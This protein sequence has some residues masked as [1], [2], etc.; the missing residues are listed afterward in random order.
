M[1]LPTML[2]ERASNPRYTTWARS[3]HSAMEVS[4]RVSR[5]SAASGDRSGPRSAEVSIFRIG[6]SEA[7][8]LEK[9]TRSCSKRLA[10]P[11]TTV[12]G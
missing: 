4:R 2:S 6:I 11:S 8:I 12:E 5:V 10:S 7:I 9:C 3:M 1:A